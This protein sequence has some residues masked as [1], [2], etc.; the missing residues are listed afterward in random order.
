MPGA[1]WVVAGPP[2][3]GKSTVAGLL[4]AALRPVPAL[5]DKD[6][7]YGSFVTATLAAA[8][9]RRG[10]ARA[11]GTTSTSRPTSTPG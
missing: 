6:T 5:L 9:A 1:A 2:G 10:N 11:R 7:M 4:L 8:G 3:A